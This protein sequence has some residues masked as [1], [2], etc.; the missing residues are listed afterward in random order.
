MKSVIDI[1]YA[2]SLAGVAVSCLQVSPAS[3]PAP[4]DL[5]VQ[6]QQRPGGIYAAAVFSGVATP[7]RCSEVS[8][9]LFTALQEARLKPVDSSSWML[10]RYNDPSVKPR[11]RR[12]EILVELQDFNLWG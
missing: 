4:T 12:N 11:F 5:A 9:E 8:S 6:L 1:V 2:A 7:R 3:L 10:A